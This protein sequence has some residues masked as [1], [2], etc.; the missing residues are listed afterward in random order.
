M[1]SSTLPKDENNVKTRGATYNLF[2]RE[3]TKIPEVIP[4]LLLVTDD[5]ISPIKVVFDATNKLF[6]GENLNEKKSRGAA[7]EKEDNQTANSLQTEMFDGDTLDIKLEEEKTQS[8]RKCSS[9]KNN[10]SEFLKKRN[11]DEVQ[12]GSALEN[13]VEKRERRKSDCP[14]RHKARIKLD[15]SHGPFQPGTP[16]I[17][18]K[19]IERVVDIEL[20]S[21]LLEKSATNQELNIANIIPP[22]SGGSVYSASATTNENPTQ[23]YRSITLNH[24]IYNFHCNHIHYTYISI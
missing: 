8:P 3:K 18:S 4:S 14:A 16:R 17:K 9:G 13:V 10:K 12:L 11:F 2:Q 23:K 22:L 7:L 1:S 15:E 5:I 19:S 6:S 20:S 21:H 24:Q